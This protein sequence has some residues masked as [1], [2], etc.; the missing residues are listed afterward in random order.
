M[1]ARIE[2]AYQCPSGSRYCGETTLS[3]TADLIG[4]V[5][6]ALTAA[7]TRLMSTVSS[8]SAGLL[9]PSV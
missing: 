7:S 1:R 3:S 6:P 2:T 9:A 4:W 8:T 5:M